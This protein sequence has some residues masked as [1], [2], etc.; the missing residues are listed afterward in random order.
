MSLGN[1]YLLKMKNPV[2]AVIA[3]TPRLN[4]LLQYALPAINQQTCM[5]DCL[6]IVSDKRSLTKK[7][8]AQIQSIV[9]KT[10][11][12]FLVNNNIQG[13]A[14]S[15]N[16]AI[17]CAKEQFLECYVAILDDDDVWHS[18]HIEECLTHS[19]NGDAYLVLSG[20]NVVIDSIT[21]DS[22][23]PGNLI[24][25]DFLAGNPGWQG[26]NTFIKLSV[27]YNVGG[28]TDGLISSN[29]RDLAIR[30]LDSIDLHITY[31]GKVTVDWQC[32]QS[33][34]ALSAPGSPQKLKGSAQFYLRYQHRMNE[35]IKNKFFMRLEDI[36][37]ISRTQLLKAVVD[38]T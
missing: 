30:V 32:N 8:Q 22:N 14:G 19:L 24:A 3:T 33:L 28:F 25:D 1:Q 38:L 18:N 21:V 31:T 20:M 16:S 36:F 35:K 13:A 10:P 4:N 11:I 17:K 27:L 7:E 23:I 37:N 9:P 26:S 34:D 12:Q 2:V 6:L 5:P 15:W 29:D